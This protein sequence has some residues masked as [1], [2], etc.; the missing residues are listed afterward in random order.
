M[1]SMHGY[2]FYLRRYEILS[3]LLWWSVEEIGFT[4]LKFE[5]LDAVYVSCARAKGRRSSNVVCGA[6][7]IGVSFTK[8][9]YIQASLDGWICEAS[10]QRSPT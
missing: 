10:W 9:T 8:T 7:Y 5:S 3:R 4:L 6:S 2:I 1:K